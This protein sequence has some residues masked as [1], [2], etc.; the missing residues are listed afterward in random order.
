MSKRLSR[1]T[2][3]SG[4]RPPGSRG[5]VDFRAVVKGLLS[6]PLIGVIA[7]LLSLP[8]WVVLIGPFAVISYEKA[9]HR[10]GYR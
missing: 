8:M 6:I 5:W 3:R 4:E 10:R 7:T 1:P 2:V 9:R